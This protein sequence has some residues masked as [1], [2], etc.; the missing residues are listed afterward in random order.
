LGDFVMTIYSDLNR[1]TPLAKTLNVDADAV[2]FSIENI[3][4]TRLNERLFNLDITANIEDLLFEPLTSTTA[5]LIYDSIFRSLSRFEPRVRLLNDS[6][7]T[8]N[9]NEDGYDVTLSFEIIGLDGTF[10]VDSSLQAR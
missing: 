6:R 8:V 10:T 3:L 5:T 4:K 2:V 1:K 9:S 7:V